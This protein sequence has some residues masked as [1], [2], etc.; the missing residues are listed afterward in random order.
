MT[1]GR[2]PDS[3]PFAHLVILTHF[4]PCFSLYPFSMPL[5]Y[6]VTPL[7]ASSASSVC[8]C[9]THPRT[10][11][12]CRRKLLKYWAQSSLAGVP[13]V[14]VAHRSPEGTVLP[15]VCDAGEG[16]WE[17][18]EEGRGGI[19]WKNQ[20][21]SIHKTIGYAAYVHSFIPMMVG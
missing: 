20:R 5:C 9:I 18:G 21:I 16:E 2:S 3:T 7:Y 12:P 19:W 13:T 14:I 11:I 17:G 6:A 1:D 10:A 15:P 4:L 8:R